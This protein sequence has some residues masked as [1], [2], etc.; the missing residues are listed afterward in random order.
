MDNQQQPSLSLAELL[1]PVI[2]NAV[3]KALT[4]H[5]KLGESISI[6]QDGEIV[7]LTGEEIPIA[8]LD[9]PDHSLTDN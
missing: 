4:R 2:Q 7:T 1:T 9:N 6:M 8:E 5:R 3:N